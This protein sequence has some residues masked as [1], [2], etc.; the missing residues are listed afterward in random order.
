MLRLDRRS[1][2][3]LYIFIGLALL[4]LIL[5]GLFILF[6]VI[7][8]PFRYDMTYFTPQYQEMYSAPGN[9]AVTLE[10]V[11]RTGDSRIYSELTGLRLKV[12]AP[13]ANPNMA[14]TIVLDV[15]ELGYFHYLYFDVRTYERAVYYI[16]EINDRWVV[17]PEDA[18]FAFNSGRWLVTFTP[19]AAIWWA[20]LF[21]VGLGVVIFRKS[22]RY[23]EELA[24]GTQK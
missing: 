22:A 12:R 17:I 20:I 1:A 5:A 19:L 23:R 10:E 13:E 2:L 15:D 24:R 11:L 8:I 9:V 14:L 16:K 6:V 18:S 7:Q 21:F 3:Y 4:P